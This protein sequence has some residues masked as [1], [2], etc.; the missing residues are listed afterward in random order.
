[1]FSF[2]KKPKPAAPAAPEKPNPRDVC[3]SIVNEIGT[4]INTKAMNNYSLLAV[5]RLSVESKEEKTNL[6]FV[7]SVGAMQEFTFICSRQQ[8][9]KLVDKLNAELNS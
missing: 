9:K 2:F 4:F 6:T 7:N 1:M 5:E 3:E 8:H